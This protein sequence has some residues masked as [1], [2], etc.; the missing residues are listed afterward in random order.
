MFHVEGKN[1]TEYREVQKQNK[2]ADIQRGHLLQEEIY[3]IILLVYAQL[4]LFHLG[5]ESSN[6]T[7]SPAHL[8]WNQLCFPRH[9]NNIRWQGIGKIRYDKG[10]VKKKSR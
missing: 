6:C 7:Q 4:L 9:L 1:V 3:I 5:L 2:K 8:S 10:K